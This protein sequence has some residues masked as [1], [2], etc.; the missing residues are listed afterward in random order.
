MQMM[1]TVACSFAA[2]LL[3][4]SCFTNRVDASGMPRLPAFVQHIQLVQAGAWGLL[5]Y[6]FFQMLAFAII[7]GIKSSCE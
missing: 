2:L 7:A 4:V 1:A 3:V 6:A 5:I